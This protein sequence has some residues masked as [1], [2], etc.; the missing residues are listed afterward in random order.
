MLKYHLQNDCTHC[1]A[2]SKKVLFEDLP[3]KK[4]LEV[5]ELAK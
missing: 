2:I 3:E 5:K 1:N 4:K